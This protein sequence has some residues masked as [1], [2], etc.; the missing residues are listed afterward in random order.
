[1]WTFALLAACIGSSALPLRPAG[2]AESTFSSTTYLRAFQRPDSSGGKERFLP[3]YE[4]LSGDA[5]QLR[6]DLPL[7]FHF[8][9][10]GRLD[11]AEDTGS[12]GTGGDFDAAYLDYR[13]P[14]GNG[15]ARLGRFFLAEGVASDTI[16]GVFV[17]G[18]TGPG[19]GG[20]LFAG[21]PVEQ[22]GGAI[23]TGR[24][25]YGGRAFFA[26]AGFAE[27]GASI[28][29]EK[30]DF[31]KGDGAIDD[32]TLAGG[33][34][35]L[36]PGGPIEFNGQASYNLATKG[37]ASQRYTVRLMPGAGMDVLA[38][39]EAY[40]YRDLFHGTLNPAFQTSIPGFDNTDK[41][42]VTFVT[43]DWE[44]M[45]GLVLEAALKNMKHNAVDPGTSSRGQAG[46]RWAWNDRKDTVGASVAATTGDRDENEYSEYR[47][48]GMWSPDDWRL[49]ADL[50]AQRYKVA[51]ADNP[52][53][54]NA[55]QAVASA[56][57]QVRPDLKVSGDLTWSKSPRLDDDY[58]GTVRLAYNFG[59]A[60]GGGK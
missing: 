55:I 47:V 16:D 58:A 21:K 15:E 4:Y 27:I 34:L 6:G 28:L 37:F 7:A 10:W 53:R 2:A 48:Y 49:A 18:R 51:F 12:R 41:V 26:A 56:G 1:M 11:L 32:R 38:G 44:F 8:A 60:A 35:W 13:H 3:L 57:Y 20:A 54:K 40:E 52:S 9:A 46:L 24:A 31:P 33:D 17:K 19:F 5:T 30:G 14:N 39:Y 22:G 42:K 29:Q 43:I 36:R 25:I 50:L 45:K 23:E 59:F